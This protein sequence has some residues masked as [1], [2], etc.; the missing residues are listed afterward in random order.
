[1]DVWGLVSINLKKAR[2][3]G[4]K[5]CCLFNQLLAGKGRN[6]SEISIA[7][8]NVCQKDLVLF[9]KQEV[10]EVDVLHVLHG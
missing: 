8:E 6:L 9:W 10:E 4:L 1:M 2:I 5:R 3:S 7:N